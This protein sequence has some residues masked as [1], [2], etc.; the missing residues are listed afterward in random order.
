MLWESGLRVSELAAL[1]L[2]DLEPHNQVISVIN[3][4]GN[5]SRRTYIDDSTMNTLC[6]YIL[7]AKI[8]ED[9]TVFGIKPN[10]MRNIVKRYGALAGI[11]IHPHTFRH[12]FAIHLVR[13]GLDLAG[14]TV[15]GLF[16]PEYHA[17]VFAIQ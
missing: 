7:S 15:V 11:T 4:K 3:G 14:A 10:Q 2:G 1:T 17:G 12:S 8:P 9:G 5:K 6:S 16:E 13:S